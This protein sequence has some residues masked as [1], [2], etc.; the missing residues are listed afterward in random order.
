MKLKKLV[1]FINYISRKVSSTQL[2]LNI[3]LTGILIVGL[4]SI[5]SAFAYHYY[6]SRGEYSLKYEINFF[7]YAGLQFLFLLPSILVFVAKKYIALLVFVI[8]FIYSNFLFINPTAEDNLSRSY[9]EFG[10]E[11]V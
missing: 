11:G 2:N 9:F 6:Y 7:K 4:L 1:I 10:K 3:L 5:S 8:G